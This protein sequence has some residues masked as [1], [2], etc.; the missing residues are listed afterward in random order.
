[1]LVKVNMGGGAD[2]DV[3]QNF[4]TITGLIDF[5][6]DFGA[7]T[8]TNEVGATILNIDMGGGADNDVFQNYGIITGLI[9]FQG[10]IGAALYPAA[11]LS[12]GKC[13]VDFAG[14]IRY[15][16]YHRHLDHAAGRFG[17]SGDDL[18]PSPPSL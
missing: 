10:D 18:T 7:D 15:L 14:R 2:N 17:V 12:G 13:E 16:L 1:M 9:D 4:G 3:F 6:G 5:Q 11:S 8:F